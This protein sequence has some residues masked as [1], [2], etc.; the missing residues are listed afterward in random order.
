MLLAMVEDIRVVLIKLAERTQTMRYLSGRAR[1][2]QMLIARET[3]GF[4][5]PLANRLG[6]WQVKWEL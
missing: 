1:E 2:T 4:L 6:V 3:R 5:H